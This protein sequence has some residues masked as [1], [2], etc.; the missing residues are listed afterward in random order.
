MIKSKKD[1]FL[2][3]R[4]TNNTNKKE[5]LTAKERTV[6]ETTV[7]K[8]GLSTKAGNFFYLGMVVT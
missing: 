7:N 3:K 4:H 8:T 5:R 1:F 2:N 6:T